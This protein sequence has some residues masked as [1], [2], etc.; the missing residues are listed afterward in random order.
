MKGRIGGKHTARVK[1]FKDDVEHC[2]KDG[3]IR[4]GQAC[5]VDQKQG[6]YIQNKDENSLWSDLVT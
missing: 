3:T 5:P 2:S 6:A 1:N 4:P